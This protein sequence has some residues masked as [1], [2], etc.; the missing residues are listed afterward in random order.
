MFNQNQRMKMMI[1]IA[2]RTDKIMI[3]LFEYVVTN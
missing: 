1:Y 2:E 3:S